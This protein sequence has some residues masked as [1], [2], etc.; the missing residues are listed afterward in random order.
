MRY[1]VILIALLIA[2]CS[3]P[4]PVD[5]DK[6]SPTKADSVRIHELTQEKAVLIEQ[7][8]AVYDSV[9]ILK[10]LNDSLSGELFLNRYKVE[11]VRFYLAICQRDRTQDKFLKGWVTRAV[12]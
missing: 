2:A 1:T 5:C 9:V 3:G 8:Q 12:E 7:N 10:R 11:K 6:C 4:R